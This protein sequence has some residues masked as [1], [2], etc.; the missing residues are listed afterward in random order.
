MWIGDKHGGLWKDKF[1][2]RKMAEFH[3]GQRLK[4]KLNKLKKKT[5]SKN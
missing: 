1:L 2:F 4:F 3:W 5:S